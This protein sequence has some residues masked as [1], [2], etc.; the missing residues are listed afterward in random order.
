MD[1]SY[2]TTFDLPIKRSIKI[3]PIIVK[4]VMPWLCIHLA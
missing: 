1:V 4:D 3:Y 2:Y